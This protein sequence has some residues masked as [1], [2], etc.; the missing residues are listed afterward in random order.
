MGSMKNI[1][2]TIF[3][4]GLLSLF[5]NS[6]PVL[7]DSLLY[8]AHTP[9]TGSYVSYCNGN[10]HGIDH[11]NLTENFSFDSDQVIS[12][13]TWYD[14]GCDSR[15]EAEMSV[16]YELVSADN[17]NVV[18][19]TKREER[20]TCS[21][22]SPSGHNVPTTLE[23]NPTT[24]V[25]NRNYYIVLRSSNDERARAYWG[26]DF[27]NQSSFQI[28]GS[29]APKAPVILVPGIMGSSLK[30]ASDSKEIWPNVNEMVLS[31]S[32]AY[33]DEL[34]L[35]ANG[36][37]IAGKEMDP[38]AMLERTSFSVFGQDLATQ[39]LYGDL[40]EQFTDRGYVLG[41]DLFEV[42]YDWRA[43]MR[44]EV[45]RLEAVI[46]AALEAAAV[47]QAI[48]GT[49]QLVSP[50][51][52][53]SIVAHSMGGLLAKQYLSI[54]GNASL[55]DKV[56]LVGAPQLG[57][58]AMF[59]VLN[60]GDNLGFQFPIIQKDILNPAEVKAI[61]Q[62]MPGTYE[63]LPSR[64]YVTAS[65][66]YI[67]DFRNG[68]AKTLSHD[69]TA[70][71]MTASS[72]DSRNSA[73]IAVGQDFHD[74]LD[75]QP[76]G[77]AT[78][79]NLVACGNPATLGEIRLYDKGKIDIGSTDGDGTV[80]LASAM[81]Q[82]SGY[83]NYFISSRDTGIDH[84]GLV[85]DDR[86]TT[87]IERL[88]EG[89][90]VPIG[91][92]MSTTSDICSEG[93]NPGPSALRFSTH[94]PVALH[95]YDSTG[96]HTGPAADGN[97]D[98][99]I[100]GSSYTTLGGNSFI[101]VPM[102]DIYRTVIDGL[103]SG[104]F[105]LKA[106]T[107]EGSRL[108]A[109][110][111]YI[112]VPLAGVSTVAEATFSNA[113]M[114]PDLELDSNGDGTVDANI[115]P[116]ARLFNVAAGDSEPPQISFSGV[117][118]GTIVAG[119]PFAITFT[120]S[121]LLSGVATTSAVLDGAPF[122][123]GATLTA[124]SAGQHT[125]VIQAT[126][127]AGNPKVITA[128]FVQTGAPA[129]N[130]PTTQDPPAQPAGGNSGGGSSSNQNSGSSQTSTIKNKKSSTGQVLGVSTTVVKQA[131]STAT[132]ASVPRPSVCLVPPTSAL[133][134][135]KA[136]SREQVLLLQAFLNGEFGLN[137]PLTG[138]FGPITELAVKIFQ[139]TH[140]A[141]VLAPAGLNAPTG[142]V[143]KYTLTKMATL[144]CV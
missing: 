73:L 136:N 44:G 93:M 50:N 13:L 54:P 46:T 63:L 48:I 16:Y 139:L 24:V 129:P 27:T 141:D 128:G 47:P 49:E 21:P 124:P 36:N 53:V 99:G 25:A 65:G 10:H 66:G 22:G 43:D 26:V 92:G 91:W 2:N 23:I 134:R 83:K 113:N 89:V 108:V 61:A 20:L 51:V 125:I 38:G 79:Y 132:S 137:I 72:S 29:P 106:G 1:K 105:T 68:E 34:K 77:G 117:P 131:S 74:A 45:A 123:S 87:L 67:K 81:H 110:T 32:D 78:V 15:D 11:C 135:G 102:G 122:A 6:S 12:A 97:I 111:N 71:L 84:G 103:D 59:K 31:G 85:R 98:I 109:S 127:K 90:S 18:A 119:T 126:D 138:F 142:F 33:L 75:G 4:F 70:A 19:V 40:V 95:V 114:N 8:E 120:A 69:E 144:A 58:P 60:Y 82:A 9:A 39:T 115:P 94:S 56:V 107:L 57:A 101:F 28:H 76:I 35:D 3:I 62:N 121:D 133:G 30:R 86:A 55:I 80:P 143:G 96:H 7:A 5:I 64:R 88:A 104:Q 140:Y 130:P 17:H 14:L 112:D 37:Q 118:T 42:A 116:T 100:P 52:K 41:V